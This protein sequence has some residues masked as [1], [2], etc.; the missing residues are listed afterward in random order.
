MKD[1]AGLLVFFDLWQ[2][3]GVCTPNEIA[4]DRW[5]FHVQRICCGSL[6][7][8]QQSNIVSSSCPQSPLQLRGSSALGGLRFLCL[9]GS[10]GATS[11]PSRLFRSLLWFL[12]FTRTLFCL[13]LYF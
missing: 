11:S 10:R 2:S 8:M 4:I 3:L 7:Y 6:K 9:W 5:K 1:M 13:K 12:I